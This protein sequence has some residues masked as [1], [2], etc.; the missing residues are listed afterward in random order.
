MEIAVKV[1]LVDDH[2]FTLEGMRHA[3]EEGGG[4]RFVQKP[5]T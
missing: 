2:A 3:L 1:L 5:R 4:W